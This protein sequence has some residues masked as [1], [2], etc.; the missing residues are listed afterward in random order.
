MLASESVSTGVAQALRRCAEG[1][2]P[3]N[4]ALM[5]LF[6]AAANVEEAERALGHAIWDA[7]ELRDDEAAIRLGTMQKLWESAPDAFSTIAAIHGLASCPADPYAPKIAQYRMLFDRAAQISPIAGVALYSLGDEAL[8]EAAT[9]E[10]VAL[11]RR[12]GLIHPQAVAL[13][14]GCGSGRFLHALAPELRFVIGVDISEAMLRCASR[15]LNGAENAAAI[16]TAGRD[17]SSLADS[18]FDLVFGIDSFPY[19]VDAGA[20][21][22]HVAEAARVLKRDGRLLVL[23]YS[24]SGD[25]ER[26]HAE[27]V[28]AATT[29]GLLEL[30][31]ALGE[32]SYW[33]GAAFLFRKPA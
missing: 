22:R 14:V 27:I 4:V 20:A 9:A 10:V 26:D 8:L 28:G 12:C 30:P 33:D 23:N 5:H 29:A 25:A 17:L 6:I 3:P 21:E 32:L 1:A 19:L 18:S 15:R 16:R 13:E 2:A 24:Y 31:V 7:L 11:M